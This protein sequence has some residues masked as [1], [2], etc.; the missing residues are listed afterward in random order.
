MSDITNNQP[1]NL[2]LPPNTAST[3]DANSN[4]DQVSQD[5]NAD[6]N[7]VSNAI[8]S[9]QIPN[10]NQITT[11]PSQQ[12]QDTSAVTNPKSMFVP[13]QPGIVVDNPDQHHILNAL[14]EVLG[15]SPRAIYYDRGTGKQIVLKPNQTYID[16]KTG[17]M[18]GGPQNTKGRLLGGLLA[19]ALEGAFA[20]FKRDPGQKYG[21]SPGAAFAKGG[22]A[23]M[24]QKQQQAQ[25]QDENAKQDFKNYYQ[26]TQANLQQRLNAIQIGRLNHEDHQ[27]MV[28]DNKEILGNIHNYDPS[29]IVAEH[30][31]ENDAKNIN[32]YPV[33]DY[34]RIPDGVVPR[35]DPNTGEQVTIDGVPQWDNT[36]S[37]VKSK[38]RKSV[39]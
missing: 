25:D 5:T 16:T 28:D 1:T 32:Q 29:D 4:T 31:T 22:Q 15:G 6:T 14:S 23:V 37:L 8:Q 30:V 9:G 3:N 33:G 27:S 26:T 35:L 19:G 13:Q 24:Q 18:V 20:G 39:V 10:P 38:D 34:L 36:Y 21:N 7:S 12:Q 17:Q 11:S 2:P